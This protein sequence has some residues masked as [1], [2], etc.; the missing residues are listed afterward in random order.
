M[1]MQSSETIRVMIVD[2]HGM[3]RKG[4]RAYL[5]SD[6]DLLVVGEARDGQE[7]LELCEGLHPDVVLM[8]LVMPAL[9][10]VAATRAIRERYPQVQVIALTSYHE[11]ELIQGAIKAGAISYLM[12]N[13]SGDEL[14]RA[15]HAAM[16]GR[17]VLAPEAVQALIQPNR[18]T[19]A[20]GADLTRRE[21]EVLALLVKGMTNPEIAERLFISRATVKAHVSNILSK[22]SVSNRSE[23]VALAVQHKL[24][25]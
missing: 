22:L 19:E 23:A 2:D 8:D 18:R 4:L 7:A 5:K 24:V 9:D 1:E 15:V 6:A 10:G 12:K 16:Q 11:K 20:V 14:A 21:L 17:P 13:V 3:V 25:G